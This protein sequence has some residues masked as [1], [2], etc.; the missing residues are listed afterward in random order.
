[1]SCGKLPM[2]AMGMSAKFLIEGGQ[3]LS[4]VIDNQGAKN[5]ALHVIAGS[6][7]ANDAVVLNNVPDLDD[8]GNMIALVS[9][10][11]ADISWSGDALEI[12]PK[13]ISSP[14][15]PRDTAEKVRS[16]LLMLGIL[17]NKLGHA[18]L[19]LPGGCAIGERKFDMHLDG[20]RA[21][22]AEITVID[23]II[24]AKAKRLKGVEFKLYYPTVTGTMNLVLA[25]ALADGTTTLKNV[26][27]N[28]EVLD[29]L[30][31]M[32]ALGTKIDGIGTKVLRIIGSKELRS[33]TFDII[34]DRIAAITYLLAGAVTGGE[35]VVNGVDSGHL[36][37]EIGILKEAGINIK[38]QN[39]RL[40]LGKS[41]S[42]KPLHLVTAAYPNFHT[43]M[44]PL[45]ASLLCLAER[46]SAIKETI[47]DSRFGYA[48]ELM[49]MGANIQVQQGDFLCVNGKQGSTAIIEGVETLHGADIRATDLRAGAALVIAALAA[50]GQTCIHNI[51]QIDRGY[52]NMEEK[53]SKIGANIIRAN[54]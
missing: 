9:E 26:A 34:Y 16:S 22:G 15:V 8:V 47:L 44:H 40:T 2:K 33:T 21:M 32:R 1:M 39:K 4:G 36:V 28:P 20:L 7:L 17:L 41:E 30:Y 23:G 49:K 14:V 52:M 6:L 13:T 42:F 19:P 43:D 50:R 27:I 46:R 51:A 35:I 24:E 48:S 45:F 37:A 18:I 53:L 10:I 11:G 5:S 31:F 29:F 38:C 54:N 12:A 25:A 3:R